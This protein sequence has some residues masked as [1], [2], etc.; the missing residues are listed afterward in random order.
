MAEARG[1]LA[2]K[3]R[4]VAVGQALPFRDIQ[5]RLSQ[6]GYWQGRSRAE[7]LLHKWL[8]GDAVTRRGGG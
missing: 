3:K 8:D 4:V 1:P 5:L 2:I 7:K 6:W